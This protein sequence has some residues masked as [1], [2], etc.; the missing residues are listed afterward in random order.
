MYALWGKEMGVVDNSIQPSDRDVGL[1]DRT[2][3]LFAGFHP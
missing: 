1:F 3:R 2:E